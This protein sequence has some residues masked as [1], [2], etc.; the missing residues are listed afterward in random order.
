MPLERLVLDSD[1]EFA[2]TILDDT[3]DT[4]LHNGRPVYSLLHNLGFRTTKT[5]WTFD[6]PEVNRG[7]Y[8]AGETLSSP[9]Y[10]E[11]VRQLSDQGFEIAFHNATMG[12]S[13][14]EDT[15][16]A[17]DFLE[18]ELNQQIRI[19]C[20]HGQNLENLHWG[21]ERY[22][23]ALLSG[24]LSLVDR[25]RPFPRFHGNDPSSP[26]YWSDVADERLSYIRAFTYRRLNGADIP[27]GRPFKDLL[28][29]RDA[30]FFNTTDA[31]DVLAF[32]K[33]VN[34]S[35][36]DK[37]RARNGWAIISTHIGKGFYHNDKLNSEFVKNMEY[38]ASRSGW[39]VP[40]SELLDH[41]R[42][43]HG[44]SELRGMECARMEFSHVIDRIIGRLFDESFYE[45]HS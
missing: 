5:V 13:S 15:I 35:S 45:S 18:R 32:N 37:L 2:F 34:R 8:F 16:K 11:W 20:N 43:C 31:P 38:L 39:F 25:L 22:N 36:I 29:Q 33:I 10:L 21:I 17:L 26:Y 40:A 30:L 42:N 9:D 24:A 7:P 41:L 6:T 19:H 3:D 4:T 12:T 14:R 44:I 27:P 28:K 23:S 1:A